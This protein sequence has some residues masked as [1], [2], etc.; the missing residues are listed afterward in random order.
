[1][2]LVKFSLLKRRVDIDRDA[3]SRHWRGQHVE[4]LL[5][6]GHR[7]YNANYV[8]NHFFDRADEDLADARF[9]GAAQLVQRVQGASPTGFQDDPRYLAQVRPDERIFLDVE[10]SCALFTRAVALHA[11]GR[12]Q[13]VKLMTFFSLRPDAPRDGGGE[14][15]VAAL[16]QTRRR[17]SVL[18]PL[19]SSHVEYLTVR[20]GS[21]RFTHASVD[22]PTSFDGVS[23]F[24][25]EDADALER[26][27]EV[28]RP[29][30]LVGDPYW[31]P[32]ASCSFLAR[33]ALVYDDTRSE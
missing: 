24:V 33:V 17:A 30:Q 6:A 28:A 25:F 1:M 20:G 10:R 12:P 4:V 15:D 13:R 3:F 31:T 21:R 7:E 23:E 29:T 32:E 5:A 27:L 26:A 8:Q 19:M 16:M 2:N 18:W 14:P 9:D 22:S 11:T